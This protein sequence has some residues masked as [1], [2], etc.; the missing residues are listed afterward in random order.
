MKKFS[1]IKIGLFA[2]S[3]ALF[4]Y[5]PVAQAEDAASI[6]NKAHLASYYAA[7]DGKASVYMEI[8]NP[9][10]GKRIREFTILR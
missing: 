8:I 5:A 1:L 9:D 7:D 6:M 2:A 3:A 4:S 10:G